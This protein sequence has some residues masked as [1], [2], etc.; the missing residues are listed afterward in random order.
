[1]RF[2]R[3]K[4][5][6]L[7]DL[8]SGWRVLFVPPEAIFCP[9]LWNISMSTIVWESE[10][11]EEWEHSPERSHFPLVEIL[12]FSGE[13]VGW[14][15]LEAQDYTVDKL[16]IS[17]ARRDVLQDMDIV[18][19]QEVFQCLCLLPDV[20]IQLSLPALTWSSPLWLP[21]ILL[22]YTNVQCWWFIL[23]CV[24][25]LFMDSSTHSC[26]CLV[27]TMT[28]AWCQVVKAFLIVFWNLI[29]IKAW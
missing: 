14:G 11:P 5:Y 22:F 17:G 15:M 2:L 20:C 4:L 24:W 26:I 9:L 27:P 1:M 21:P 29:L 3:K 19:G 7:I 12:L 16:I 10:L 23:C 25:L 6:S 28:Q 18:W 8:A 13:W